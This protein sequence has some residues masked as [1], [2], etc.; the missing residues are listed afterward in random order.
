MKHVE[1]PHV[2]QTSRNKEDQSLLE[3]GQL[4]SQKSTQRGGAPAIPA[5]D[6]QEQTTGGKAEEIK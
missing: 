3:E 2:S 6:L 1:P 4:V 5:K